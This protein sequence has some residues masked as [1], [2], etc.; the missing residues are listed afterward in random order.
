MAVIGTQVT[1]PRNTS[2][3]I[4]G[5]MA[6]AVVV[7]A[8]TIALASGIG[9]RSS[10]T[11]SGAGE[12]VAATTSPST[13]YYVLRGTPESIDAALWMNGGPIDNLVMV[14][15]AEAE[16]RFFRFVET[17]NSFLL[18]AGLP[19]YGVVNLSR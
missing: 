5:A 4:L 7:L 19:G 6:C 12:S 8:I 3:L 11:G 9:G 17:A 15:S 18:A 10:A 16:D 13:T 1:L 14:E 2:G